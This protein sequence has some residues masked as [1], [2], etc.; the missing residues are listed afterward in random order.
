MKAVLKGFV[1]LSL[2]VRCAGGN[3]GLSEWLSDLLQE[4]ERTSI[5]INSFTQKM[6]DHSLT[7]MPDTNTIVCPVGPLIQLLTT[8]LLLDNLEDPDSVE[9]KIRQEIRLGL[10]LQEDEKEDKLLSH[11]TTNI[12]SSMTCQFPDNRCIMAHFMLFPHKIPEKSMTD[13]KVMDEDSPHHRRNYILQNYIHIMGIDLSNPTQI[14]K[15]INQ[16]AQEFTRGTITNI[17][18]DSDFQPT[19]QS[20]FLSNLFLQT[21][22]IKPFEKAVIAFHGNAGPQRVH[23]LKSVQT[24][25]IYE[26]PQESEDPFKILYLLANEQI[27]FLIKIHES[28]RVSPIRVE[29]FHL[30]A[31]PCS[32]VLKLPRFDIS[33]GLDLTFLSQT[34]PLLFSQQYKTILTENP[35]ALSQFKQKNFITLDETGLKAGSGTMK[36]NRFLSAGPEKLKYIDINAPF[37]FLIIEKTIIDQKK[38]QSYFHL[39]GGS[40]VNPS[41]AT[42]PEDLIN[43]KKTIQW[44][45]DQLQRVLKQR[46][47]SESEQVKIEDLL[48]LKRNELNELEDIGG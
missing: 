14:A 20:V 35:A 12:A 2:M 18:K 31:T 8:S 19:T 45:I 27:E 23:G 21:T 1:G 7:Q 43:Y 22:W 5:I 6:V 44:D 36:V 24:V 32:A 16:L 47:I 11:L 38:E 26:S 15:N 37:S 41:E 34:F 4:F 40:I 48:K 33:Q 3:E 30:P 17:A 46:N 39:F 25:Y 29:E 13:L 9:T 10:G 28:R 42:A